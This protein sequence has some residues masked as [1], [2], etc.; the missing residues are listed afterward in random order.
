[1]LFIAILQTATG[2]FGLK[3][4]TNRLEKKI[5]FHMYVKRR[6]ISG[7]KVPGR[8]SA[9]PSGGGSSTGYDGI[10]NVGMEYR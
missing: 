8:P 10:S 5:D 9:T 7:D 1:M 6:P 2:F 3:N 4:Q